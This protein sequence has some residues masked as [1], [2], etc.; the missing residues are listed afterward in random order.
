MAFVR[1]CRCRARRTLNRHPDEYVR[2]PQCRA[3]GCRS[4]RYTVDA[5]RTRVE[6]GG[7]VRPCKC[8]GYS[9]P[10]RRGSG[11]CEHNPKLTEEMLRERWESGSWS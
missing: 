5:Y 1:C 7:K 9:F 2:L 11:Y 3:P 6:R 4:R 10:H 8:Y